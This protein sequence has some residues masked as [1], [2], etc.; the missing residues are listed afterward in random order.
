MAWAM[1]PNDNDDYLPP[2]W[3]FEDPGPPRWVKGVMNFSPYNPDNTNRHFLLTGA[4]G[5]YLQCKCSKGKAASRLMNGSA[6]PCGERLAPDRVA[7][8][9][10]HRNPHQTCV[11]IGNRT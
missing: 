3:Y 10:L 8:Q 11:R 2:N 1:Y 4:L 9:T 7:P 6:A 5:R